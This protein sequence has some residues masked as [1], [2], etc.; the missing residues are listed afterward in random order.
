MDKKFL[1]EYSTQEKLAYNKFLNNLIKKP[2]DVVHTYPTA[3]RFNGL[4][5]PVIHAERYVYGF[6]NEKIWSQI[7]FAGT[8]ILSLSNTPPERC[9]KQNGFEPE[10]IPKLIDLAKET[11]KIRFGLERDPLQY[12]GL[13]YL[14]P[15]FDEFQPPTL[16]AI[17]TSNFIS[18]KTAMMHASEFVELSKVRY[19]DELKY[20]V[21]KSGGNKEFFNSLFEGRGEVYG[22]MKILGLEKEIEEVSKFLIDDPQHAEFLLNSYMMITNPVFDA[23]TPNYNYSLSRILNSNMGNLTDNPNIKIP[24]VGK[25]IMKKLIPNPI[26]YYSCIDVIQ[27]YRENDLY[28]LLDAFDDAIRK[29]QSYKIM[30]NKEELE[31]VVDN[32]WSDVQKM[33]SN[34]QGIKSGLSFVFGLGGL[35]GTSI[36]QSES[37]VGPIAALSGLIAGL[38]FNTIESHFDN[39]KSSLS[40]RILKFLKPNYIIS[41]YDFKKKYKLD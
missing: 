21:L 12:E 7:P 30:E 25:L 38:G 35:Y 9:L 11:G 6:D 23:L 2:K 27:K 39:K 24:E 34:I 3:E 41:V 22:A 10:D 5:D 19:Y 18:D 32:I 17:P 36:L 28:K 13:D 16:Y 4:K 40:E 15:I 14:Q 29:K 31:T 37:V 8:L 26:N 1:A 33:G 20:N